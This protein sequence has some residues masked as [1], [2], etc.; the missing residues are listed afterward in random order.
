MRSYLIAIHELSLQ[1]KN[2]HVSTGRLAS[3]LGVTP[4]TV[5]SMVKHL[6][7]AG[8]VE[9]QPYRGVEFTAEGKRIAGKFA[10]RRDLLKQ[11]FIETLKL[12]QDHA[13]QEA[14]RLESFAS[15][16]LISHIEKRAN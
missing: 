7:N 8:L 15:D 10:K 3:L 11:F 4:G 16:R 14:S 6:R 1:T 9:Y 5:T 12:P 2:Q 13:H